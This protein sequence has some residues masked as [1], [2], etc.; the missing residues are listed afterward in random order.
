MLSLHFLLPLSSPSVFALTYPPIVIGSQPFP[1]WCVIIGFHPSH[2]T[3][4]CSLEVYDVIILD[5]RLR[6]TAF[7]NQTVIVVYG[8]HPRRV[9][10]SLNSSC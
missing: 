10:V 7:P 6:G 4:Q 2:I 3:Q 5:D 8:G 1:R 9:D